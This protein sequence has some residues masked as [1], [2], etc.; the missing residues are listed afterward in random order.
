MKQLQARRYEAALTQ[1]QAIPQDELLPAQRTDAQEQIVRCLLALNRPEE[2][3]EVIQ[4][5]T[6]SPAAKACRMRLMM[7]NRA[8]QKVVATFRDEDI[9]SWPAYLRADAYA[10]RARSAHFAQAGELA[11]AD[12]RHAIKWEYDPNRRNSLMLY[13]ADLHHTQLENDAKAI[14]IY[15][16]VKASSGL[17]DGARATIGMADIHLTQ[18]QPQVA[19]RLMEDWLAEIDIAGFQG[20]WWPAYVRERHAHY[21]AAAGQTQKA[22]DQYEDALRFEQTNPALKERIQAALN[23]LKGEGN[24]ARTDAGDE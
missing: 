9:E 20:D 7:H 22:V 19:L 5:I 1:F 17:Y 18:D 12:Y 11:A 16:Q 6:S 23:Q 3:E 15:Q 10:N 13:L 4:Q 21:L 24:D 8:W 14:E 2:A